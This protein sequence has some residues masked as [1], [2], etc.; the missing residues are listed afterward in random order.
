MTTHKYMVFSKRSLSSSD[1]KYCEV[2]N[3]TVRVVL[4]DGNE[5][6]ETFPS[7]ERAQQIWRDLEKFTRK[8]K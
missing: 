8:I 1:L 6:I 3:R 4:K 2:S 7:V 5:L